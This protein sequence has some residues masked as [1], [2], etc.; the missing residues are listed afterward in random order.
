MS[1]LQH[2]LRCLEQIEWYLNSR[3]K[4][5]FPGAFLLSAGNLAR[6]VLEQVA[7]ILAF[8]SRMPR[9][10]YLRDSHH[11]RSLDAIFRAL[12]ET[13]PSS[14]SPYLKVAARQGS[15]IR[16]FAH[17]SRSFD[18][19]RRLLNEPSHFVSA[20]AGRKIREKHLREFVRRLRC[21]VN[22]VDGYL[23]VAAVNE[24][25]S[26]GFI[27]AVLGQEPENIPGAQHTVVV[28]P[29]MFTYENGTFKMSHEMRQVIVSKS[30]ELPYRWRRAM[31]LV[32]DSGGM[33]M[34][35]QYVTR[36]GKP[37]NLTNLQTVFD[38]FINDPHE[39]GP[40]LKRMKRFGLKVQLV[41]KHTGK[42]Y[43]AGE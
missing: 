13:D 32:Q 24:I 34:V 21:V 27:K 40:F 42:P 20:A 38:E 1:L 41:E 29:R 9:H 17:L 4:E 3:D 2:P 15:R 6:Q 37:V 8:Y 35:V 16:K 19:W 39:R 36:Q 43:A 5:L 33:A 18:R 10:K 12:K 23:L 14:N 22:E 26:N 7:F 28:T 11:L 31:V 30:E 25:R